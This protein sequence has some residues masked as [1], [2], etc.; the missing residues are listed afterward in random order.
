MTGFLSITSDTKNPKIIPVHI[1][2]FT[3]ENNSIDNKG[4]INVLEKVI[5]QTI[6]F[7]VFALY[8]SFI[9]FIFIRGITAKITIM[10]KVAFG[11]SNNKGVA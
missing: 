2:V 5:Q 9:L 8:K 11:R 1:C 3:P 4:K 7:S 10:P 6:P